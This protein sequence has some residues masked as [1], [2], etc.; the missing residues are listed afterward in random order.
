MKTVALRSTAGVEGMDSQSAEKVSDS[1]AGQAS[2][3]LA[4]G[5]GKEERC[6]QGLRGEEA[7]HP[8]PQRRKRVKREGWP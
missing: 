3:M 4:K 8:E 5:P 7:R 6:W 1:A 2:P